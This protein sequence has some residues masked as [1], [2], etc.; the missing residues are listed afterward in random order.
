LIRLVRAGLEGSQKSK[1]RL[2]AWLEA[3][4]VV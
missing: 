3:Y 1:K 4:Y 2:R